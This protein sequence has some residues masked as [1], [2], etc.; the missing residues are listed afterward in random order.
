MIED[1]DRLFEK[2]LTVSYP[3]TMIKAVG[4]IPGRGFFPVGM[5][6]YNNEKRIAGKEVMILGQD[7]DCDA[8]YQKTQAAG[9]EDTQKNATWRNLLSFLKEVDIS[10]DNCFFTNAI[11]GIRKGDIG[12]GKSPAFTD[13]DFIASCQ[14]FFLYQLEVQKPQMIFALGKYVA[15]FLSDTSDDL[16]CWRRIRNFQEVDAN[17]QQVI[18]ANFKNGIKS[19]VI[20]LTHPS[21][22][23]V[24]ISRRRFKETFS[25]H[26]AEVEMVRSAIGSMEQAASSSFP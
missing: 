14:K 1:I 8:N 24:N 2:A 11:L 15:E 18:T 9:Y 25:G 5:G 22:R 20:L 10:P 7:F 23:P 3:E 4:T 19:H 21:Y 16:S 26:D 13:K 12:T 17:E 6:S